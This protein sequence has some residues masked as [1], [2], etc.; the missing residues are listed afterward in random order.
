MAA[1]IIPCVQASVLAALAAAGTVIVAPT[2]S[3]ADSIYEVEGARANARAGGP[4]SEHDAWLLDR[5]GATSG[6]PNWRH[7]PRYSRFQYDL[8]DDARPHRYS[9]RKTRAYRY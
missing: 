6:T 9:K 5:Y 2:V 1:K 4:V 8:Y 7:R 3:L